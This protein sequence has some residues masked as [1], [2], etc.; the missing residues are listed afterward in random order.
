M[1]EKGL[2]ENQLSRDLSKG[3]IL[4]KYVIDFLN[5]YKSSYFY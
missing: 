3:V 4:D 5:N 2:G 1:E